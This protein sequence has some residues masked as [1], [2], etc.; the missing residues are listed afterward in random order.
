M[1]DRDAT[2]LSTVQIVQ[3]LSTQIGSLVRTELALARAEMQAK[4]R[5]LAVGVGLLA[6]ATVLLLFASAAAIAAVVLALALVIPGWA[7]AL[8]TAAGLI[9]LAGITVLIGRSVLR[10]AA[11]PVPTHAVADLKADVA[12][13]AAAARRE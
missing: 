8:V 3:N 2:E 12:T 6:A 13:I 11:P 9:L 10:R 1:T 5:G 4:A 7:A